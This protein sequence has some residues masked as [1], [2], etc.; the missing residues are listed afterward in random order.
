MTFT[1]W[2]SVSLIDVR[3]AFVVIAFSK[4]R[5]PQNSCVPRKRQSLTYIPSA[6]M[7][8]C[9]GANNNNDGPILINSVISAWLRWIGTWS[10]ADWG[11]FI[12]I[13]DGIREISDT[14]YTLSLYEELVQY[15]GNWCSLITKSRNGMPRFIC[16]IV[17]GHAIQSE[18]RVL[19]LSQV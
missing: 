6:L 8:P 11:R 10:N 19:R 14:A 3:V 18:R 9:L 12:L 5:N 16:N 17:G 7:G 13:K 1:A 2:L 15:G 4:P